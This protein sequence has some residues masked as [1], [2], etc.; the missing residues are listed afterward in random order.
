MGSYTLFNPGITFVSPAPVAARACYDALVENV[1]K[2]EVL[3]FN[4]G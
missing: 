1:V 3:L 4:T 2:V